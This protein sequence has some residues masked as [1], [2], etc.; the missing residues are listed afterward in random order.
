M[1]P[2]AVAQK[3]HITR[4]GQLG[5]DGQLI[6]A[7]VIARAPIRRRPDYEFIGD[8]SKVLGKVEE[9]TSDKS[10]GKY[11]VATYTKADEAGLSVIVCAVF[12][13]ETEPRTVQVM[14]AQAYPHFSTQ[15]A[16]DPQQQIGLL[17]IRKWARRHT[18][19]VLP[20]VYA[21]GELEWEPNPAPR[22]MGPVDEVR[23][24][25]APGSSRTNS[26]KERMRKNAT[27]RDPPPLDEVLKAIADAATPDELTAAGERATKFRTDREK[28]IAHTAYADKLNAARVA[29]HAGEKDSEGAGE[30]V[31]MSFAQVMDGLEKAD[32]Q[33]VNF[34]GYEVMLPHINTR[35]EQHGDDEVLTLDLKITA[36]LPNK[37]LDQLSATLRRSLYD[38]DGTGDL[39]DPDNT[40]H[41][42][43]PQL[44]KLH[45]A[46][47]F[48]PVGFTFIDPDSA[49]DDLRFHDAKLDRIGILPKEGGTCE[50]DWR[51][52][53]HPEDETVSAHVL[54]LLH[55]P[56]VRGTME[57]SSDA[58]QDDED[59]DE[60]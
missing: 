53:V 5:Y 25:D 54:S 36:D 42:R 39:I 6:A 20:G 4:S 18:P 23:R 2:F 52:Q 19:D 26:V 13:G 22:N 47:E 14:M 9:R 58:L 33:W 32:K 3:T 10:Q 15:W 7:V 24:D 57:V 44:G 41:L 45:W 48:S 31:A 40:P 29:A 11:Y 55:R 17:A 49:A 30:P 46:G 60:G 8:W 1:D 38:A 28:E 12:K 59:R 51:L 16:T 37:V 50:F 56:D 27:A 34:T 43:N 35:M 21:S